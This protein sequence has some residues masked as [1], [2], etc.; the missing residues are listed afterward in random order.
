[1]LDTRTWT[2]VLNYSQVFHTCKQL[3]FQV[4]V[5]RKGK[6]TFAHVHQDWRMRRKLAESVTQ[7]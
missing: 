6:A 7:R 4:L 2:K 1:M 3:S 5:I